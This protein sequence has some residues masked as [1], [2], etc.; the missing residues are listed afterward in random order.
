MILSLPWKTNRGPRTRKLLLNIKF[1]PLPKHVWSVQMAALLPRSYH[2]GSGK[3]SR[4]RKRG[5]GFLGWQ[6]KR[7]HR[8]MCK[9][10]DSEQ[11]ARSI[12]Q[13]V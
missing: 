10:L 3:D 11:R 6:V 8:S 2:S 4:V 12:G 7:F 5:G 13:I 9:A 1:F